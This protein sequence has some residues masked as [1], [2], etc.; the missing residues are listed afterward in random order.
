MDVVK[1]LSRVTKNGTLPTGADII[2]TWLIHAMTGKHRFYYIDTSGNRIS[3]AK[4]GT[5]KER[6]ESNSSETPLTKCTYTIRFRW[7]KW[8]VKAKIKCSHGTFKGTSDYFDF[9]E[10]LIR[11]VVAFNDADHP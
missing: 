10:A 11:A 3:E 1:E 5:Y 9:T 8:N 2:G 7:N 6:Y 4:E